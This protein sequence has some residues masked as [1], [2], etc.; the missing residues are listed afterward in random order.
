M[1]GID[2]H[3]QGYTRPCRQSPHESRDP[4]DSSRLMSKTTRL[5]LMNA[6]GASVP[7][8]S[9]RLHPWTPAMTVLYGLRRSASRTAGFRGRADSY[10]VL[11]RIGQRASIVC[12]GADSAN[13]AR[14]PAAIV[15]TLA[16]AKFATA[17]YIRGERCAVD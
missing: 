11:V 12:V 5:F 9:A 3:I 15:L 6:A 8:R 4:A 2:I 16:T 1:F 10:C 14:C 13:G 7:W 17:R